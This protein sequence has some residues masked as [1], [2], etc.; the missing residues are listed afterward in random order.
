MSQHID[1]LKTFINVIHK[2]DPM[3]LSSSNV[4]EYGVEALSILSRFFEASL[5]L[6]EDEQAIVNLSR[7]IVQQTFEFW[8]NDPC[9][10]INHLTYDLLKAYIDS[11]QPDEPTGELKA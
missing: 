8:F 6:A 5:Q 2:H 4:D 7:A 3:N 9:E 11:F 10:K 1:L